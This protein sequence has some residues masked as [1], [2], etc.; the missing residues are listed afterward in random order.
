[1][2]PLNL[3]NASLPLSSSIGTP[4]MKKVHSA[5]SLVSNFVLTLAPPSH[6]SNLCMDHMKVK[7]SRSTL[8]NASTFLECGGPWGSPIVLAPKPHQEHITEIDQFVWQMCVSYRNLNRFTLPY[9]YPIPRCLDAIENLG[10]SAGHLYYISANAQQGF[11]QIQVQLS[12]KKT[13]HTA[14]MWK[15]WQTWH[16]RFQ[17]ISPTDVVRMLVMSCQEGDRL[18]RCG[19]LKVTMQVEGLAPCGLVATVVSKPGWWVES[20]LVSK[21]RRV[22]SKP[23]RVVSKPKDV[24]IWIY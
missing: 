3:R 23:R 7:L 17:N 9:E 24:K 16:D 14:M 4:S 20:H 13:I 6:A 21:P 18:T 15:L 12:N 8:Q 10:D 5:Q 1:M 19:E 22:V 11:H 2:P